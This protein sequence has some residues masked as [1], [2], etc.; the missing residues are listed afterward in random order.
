MYIIK[1]IAKNS[2]KG[3][4][5]IKTIG[6]LLVI[7]TCFTVYPWTLL[8]FLPFKSRPTKKLPK[9]TIPNSIKTPIVANGNRIQK[10]KAQKYPSYINFSMG[11]SN[12]ATKHYVFRKLSPPSVVVMSSGNEHPHPLEP[13][14]VKSSKELDVILVGSLAP[15]GDKSDFSS[16]GSEVFITA[17]SDSY[18]TA[19]DYD[20]DKTD[21]S[22][23]SGAAPL[24]TGSLGTF[25]TLAGYHPTA[26][27]AKTLLKNTAIP[28]P[29]SV[30]RG[31]GYGQNGHG[32]VNAYKL[33]MVGK[34][35]KKQCGQSAS[36]FSQGINNPNTYKFPPPDKFLLL[37]IRRS[38]PECDSQCNKIKKSSNKWQPGCD[39][40][41]KVFEELRKQA[42]L[43]PHNA[44]LWR[45]I[46][47]IY[48]SAGF[49][50]DAK[51]ALATYKAINYKYNRDGNHLYCKSDA[52]CT[53]VPNKSCGN[54]GFFELIGNT[55]SSEKFKPYNKH[56]A[57]L[58]YLKWSWDGNSP[59]ACNEAC[60]CGNTETVPV[61][62]GENPPKKRYESRCV[63]HI[64]EISVHE[65]P[66]KKIP[67]A[68]TNP[69]SI[70][71][72][73]TPDRIPAHGSSS[74]K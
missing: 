25:E 26:K 41:A 64:C 60:R 59:P 23:T 53:L 21:F 7:L 20:G 71:G 62:E 33:A 72:A 56:A 11:G 44:D 40:K 13:I 66:A 32:M 17:P 28:V 69:T 52:D 14:N 34:K 43:N 2:F 46:A 5:K 27:E 74:V 19:L 70:G 12:S 16:Q 50:E 24:V 58:C 49:Y 67:K 51:G 48:R 35:L 31:P 73:S 39:R 36:C 6:L 55:F 42:F 65:I 4:N 3:L 37:E 1:P 68:T 54:D 22:G 30:E 8:D 63:N 9:P 38:F 61:E 45:N 15:N 29:S 10:C 47:C 18:I 57:E